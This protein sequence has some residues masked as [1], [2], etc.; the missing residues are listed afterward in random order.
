[1]G[2]IQY[3]EL[4]QMGEHGE[5]VLPREATPDGFNGTLKVDPDEYYN[6]LPGCDKEYSRETIAA[7]RLSTGTVPVGSTWTRNPIPACKSI[8]GGAFNLGC[9]VSA[10]PGKYKPTKIT[11]FQFPPPGKDK[12][13]ADVDAY[14]AGFGTG[15]CFGCNQEVNPW[16]C[17]KFGKI[18]RNNCSV[19][20]TNA[21]TFSF[22]VVDKVKVPKVPA[23]KYVVSFRW[24]S[25]QTPQI[26]STC[27]DVTIVDSAVV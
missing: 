26:W 2:D 20:E 1:M 21:Q 19:D 7:M 23:G 9:H 16:D 5:G 8:A 27:S 15:A 4:P 25:E 22:N 12:V 17:N 6:S 24:E 14:L 11:D 13:R 10:T 3:C 18:G